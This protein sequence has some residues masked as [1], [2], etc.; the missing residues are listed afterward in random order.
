MLS[1]DI[2]LTK[3]LLY[4]CT[5]TP[6]KTEPAPSPT[7]LCPISYIPPL[8]RPLS[9]WPQSYDFFSKSPNVPPFFYTPPSFFHLHYFITTYTIGIF[10][11]LDFP[12]LTFTQYQ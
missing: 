9:N 12:I 6:V 4:N 1:L 11:F 8:L 7:D 2:Y 3:S 10:Q 5:L